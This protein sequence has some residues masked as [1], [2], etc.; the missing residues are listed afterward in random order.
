MLCLH[1]SRNNKKGK[2]M[3]EVGRLCVK[4]AGRDA[5]R[6]CVIVDIIDDNFVLVDGDT[7][8]RKCNIKHIEPLDTVIKIK[9]NAGHEDIVKEFKQLGIEIKERKSK[10]KTEKPKKVRKTKQKPVSTEP[11]K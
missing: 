5:A 4:I 9:K 7:R 6:K 2:K 1:E 3:I 8:R 10:P 11:K